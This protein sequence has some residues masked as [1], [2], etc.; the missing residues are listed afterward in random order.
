MGQ[1]CQCDCDDGQHELYQ[2][3][4]MNAKSPGQKVVNNK[5]GPQI[6]A[7]DDNLSYN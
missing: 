3:M 4:V 2:E 6:T 5:G 1:A 7:A